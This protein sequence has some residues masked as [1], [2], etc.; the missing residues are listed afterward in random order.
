MKTIAML[1]SDACRRREA[2]K[3][4]ERQNRI[5]AVYRAHPE[6]ERI[7]RAIMLERTQSLIRVTE[8]DL[9]ASDLPTEEEKALLIKRASLL[10]TT[11]TDPEFDS[12]FPVCSKCNDT[13]YIS[14]ERKNTV[15]RKVC[16]CMKEELKEAYAEAGLAD[17]ESVIPSSFDPAFIERSKDKR[18]LVNQTLVEGVLKL[19]AGKRADTFIYT[20]GVQSGK[21]FLT[22][23]FAKFAIELGYSVMYVKCD[24]IQS[25][26]GDTI[27]W[28]KNCDVLLVDDF[29]SGI[30]GVYRIS[31]IL[32]SVMDVR[33]AKG[34]LSVFVTNESKEEIVAKCEERVAGKLSAAKRL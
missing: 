14:K 29:S 26:E 17:Y 4:I 10:R 8:Q 32:N 13:G 7:D 24:D 19:G 12:E 31:N 18:K 9:D 28:M 16:S 34:L 1:I 22:I 30:T 3:E 15:I 25:F 33:N 23:C 27:D 21:T 5:D 20:D 2:D 11:G 6:I